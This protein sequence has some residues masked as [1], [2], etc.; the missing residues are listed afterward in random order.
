M[1]FERQIAEIALNR[2]LSRASVVCALLSVGSACL[3]TVRPEK[4]AAL[5][6]KLETIVPDVRKSEAFESLCRCKDRTYFDE[7]IK[8][9]HNKLCRYVRWRNL[10]G[11]PLESLLEDK[12]SEAA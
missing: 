5:R 3:D 8:D 1:T 10:I 2:G 9:Y 6:Q 11:D 4:Q 12:E 7:D